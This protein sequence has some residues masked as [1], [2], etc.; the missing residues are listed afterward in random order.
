MEKLFSI[1]VVCLN[2]GEKLGQT[3][4]SIVSQTFNDYEIIIKD[5]GSSDG[6]LNILSEFKDADIRLLEGPDKGIYD[7]MNA[8][9]LN[10]R[11]RY[12]YFLNCGDILA[13]DDVLYGI[14]ESI[15]GFEKECP[16]KEAIFYGNIY[17]RHSK[18]T[19]MS[20][21]VMNE[22]GCYRNVPCH[23]AC[24]YKRSLIEKHLFDL[25]YKVR[26]DYEQF[27]WCFLN[28][29]AK[30]RYVD[31]TVADYEG[32]GYSESRPGIALSK[33]EHRRITAKYM[34]RKKIFKYR[35][36][37]LISLSGLRSAMAK[38]SLLSGV[39]NGIKKAVYKRKKNI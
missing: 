37:M 32:D 20:N 11:G 10:A 2:P 6:S 26:A 14:S 15:A 25:D 3:I 28:K 8:A 23:Q 30:T 4:N 5:G 22:F 12:I 9:L 7:A 31:I 19:V 38:S 35:L 27:L 24:F 21:P 39:Y 16:D 29:G 1:I 18:S 13:S 36:I 17:E 34:S 33:Q